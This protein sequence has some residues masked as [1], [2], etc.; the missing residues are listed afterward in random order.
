MMYKKQLPLL[1]CLLF[2]LE[3]TAEL[4]QK[5]LE[6]ITD[7][8]E[9]FS[10]RIYSYDFDVSNQDI[11][12]AVYSKPIINS[13]LAQII[14]M[15]KPIGGHWPKE[16]NRTILESS[17]QI[18]SVSTNLIINHASNTVHI[19]YIV[20]RDFIDNK[21]DTHNAGLVYQKIT[22]NTIG[23]KISISP[24]GFHSLMQL[25]EKGQAIFVREYEDFLNNTP[26]FLKK[27]RIQAPLAN[28]QWTDRSHILN[29]PHAEDYR[30]ANFVYDPKVKRY[31][32]SYGNKDANFLR[33]SYPTT[34]PPVAKGKSGVFF[35]S[36]AGHDL[37][38]AYSD[39]LNTWHSSSIDNTGSLSENEFWTDLIV[40]DNQ[41][42]S[43]SY[44]Y[45][46]DNNGI[47]QG[48]S[49]IFGHL[50][51]NNWNLTT[52]AG[53]TKGASEHRAGMGAKIIIDNAGDFHGIWDNSPDTPIDSESAQGTV[54]YRY[55]KKGVS[56]E[57]RQI[58]LP[59][60]V[61]GKVK[62]KIINNQLL[63][64]FLGDATNAKLVFSEFT[65]P[66]PT[67]NIIEISSDK[68]FYGANDP[69]N[70][71]ARIQGQ[72]TVA[73]LYFVVT[74][75]FDKNT[76]GK[77]VPTS[78]TAFHYFGADFNW[79]KVT[80]LLDSQA[81]L[82][83]FPLSSFNDFFHQRIAKN[84]IPFA[85]SGRYRLYSVATKTGLSLQNYQPLTPLYTY[86]LHI[87]NQANCTE[88]VSK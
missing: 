19:S 73:D 15:S 6:T 39:D 29:L 21:G 72:Q 27:L 14:Y 1:F 69:I 42:Y 33:Q 77:L 17:G 46:T 34:N 5:N 20:D 79:H 71:Y 51:G 60:S 68:M 49:S 62:A 86:D 18:S 3:A 48:T 24:G 36:G 61:E 40:N 7:S 52:V 64:M 66:T 12:H 2:S 30:L 50:S 65:I 57:T 43:A 35:P 28:N 47:H 63:I 54:M 67:E 10:R 59:F 11:V 74:G 37:L 78:T 53:K 26:P 32:I 45:K 41:V 75:P 82:S 13:H 80:D 56:W 83:G 23:N 84:S 25:N 81:V 70:L 31:H 88:L 4:T 22:S 16:A 76:A 87:C 44:R 9:P 8:E 38:Y 85:N 55:S 58:L